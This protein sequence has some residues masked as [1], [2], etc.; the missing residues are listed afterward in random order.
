M[1]FKEIQDAVLDDRFSESKRARVKQDINYR[2]WRIWSQEAW[3]FKNGIF[4]FS[5]PAGTSTVTLASLGIQRLDTVWDASTFSTSYGELLAD[6]PEDFYKWASGVGGR[7]ASF[8]VVGDTIRFDRAPTVTTDFVAVGELLWEE[9]VNDN[10]V[11]L[12]PAGSHKILVHGAVS[13]GLRTENDPTWQAAEQDFQAGLIDLQKGYLSAVRGYNDS[14]P[15][16]P[17]PTAVPSWL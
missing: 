11:P 4:T 17:G 16:F 12:L 10:D 3:T 15:S 14:W 8:T 1:T 6:R 9:L 7:T 5:L 2:Y 13:E